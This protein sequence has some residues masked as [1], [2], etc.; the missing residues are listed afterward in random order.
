M[1]ELNYKAI[2]GILLLMLA[3]ATGTV[4][5]KESAGYTK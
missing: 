3:T 2:G 1:I 5:I 4:Y